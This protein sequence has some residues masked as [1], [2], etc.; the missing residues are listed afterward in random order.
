MCYAVT[1]SQREVQSHNG[2]RAAWF[3]KLVHYPQSMG[4]MS[5]S[6]KR[7]C[8]FIQLHFAGMTKGRMAQVMS[9]PY[10]ARERCITWDSSFSEIPA[11][12]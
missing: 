11:D 9:Y 5:E 7:S 8:E 12:H 3:L 6:A 1:N 10:C 2:F 4:L